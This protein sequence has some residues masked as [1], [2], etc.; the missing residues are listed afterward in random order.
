MNLKLNDHGD[1]GRYD[2]VLDVIEHPD[3]YSADRI[4]EIMSDP[5]T[6]E[7]YN[8]LCKTYSAVGANRPVD[9]D[10]EWKTFASRHVSRPRRVLIWPGNRAASI[11]VIIFS[12]IVAVAAGIAVAVKVTDNKL[13]QETFSAG[14]EA[15]RDS[16]DGYVSLSEDTDSVTIPAT[17]M[18]ENEPL[19]KIMD[20]ISSVYDVKVQFNSRETAALHLYY[21]LDPALPLDEVISQ[22]NTFDL[23]SIRRDGDTL[24]V[25]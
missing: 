20:T 2:L 8:L 23:I 9:V 18:F 5:E 16:A 22:L 4:A 21:K 3:R 15:V 7:I 1:A 24:I 11:A 6:R 12:S 14:S 13:R 17:V 25:R 10:K 19:E